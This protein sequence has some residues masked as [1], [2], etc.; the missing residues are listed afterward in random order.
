MYDVS[1]APYL[2]GFAAGVFPALVVAIC[3]VVR[4]A[5]SYV[6]DS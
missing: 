3:I 6:E 1:I 5:F 2:Y 4:N